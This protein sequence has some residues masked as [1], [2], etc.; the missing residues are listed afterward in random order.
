VALTDDELAAAEP[1]KTRTID[2]D[3]FV[4]LADIDPILFD[5]PYFLLPPEGEGAARAYRLLAEV[6][7]KSE[8]AAIGRF[9]LRTKEYLVAIRV[10]DGALALTTMLFHD[11]VRPAK[12]VPGA[13]SGRKK[14]PPKKQVDQ[15]IELID[16]MTR[17]FDPS[18]Y[19]DR[20]RGRLQ[21]IV[22]D[23]KKGKTVKPPPDEDAPKAAPDLLAALEE[24]LA[25][26]RKKGRSSAQP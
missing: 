13:P 1:R 20:H 17:R 22:R 16:T 3:E 18:R 11:E 15:A 23:K 26:A 5:H 14:A 7:E 21:K 24:S 10:R 8:K 4:S 25:N 6:M 19:E 9:V 12:D 2:I